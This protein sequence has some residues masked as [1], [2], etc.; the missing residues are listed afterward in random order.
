MRILVCVGKLGHDWHMMAKLYMWELLVTMRKLGLS[1]RLHSRHVLHCL[2]E[3][4]LGCGGILTL[5]GI[6][7][8]RHILR[9]CC[10]LA[11]GCIRDQACVLL[12]ELRLRSQLGRVREWGPV[13]GLYRCVRLRC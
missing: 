7:V 3:V 8:G 9:L 2:S 6:E 10:V 11:L 4:V 12:S 1:C 13:N 5:S